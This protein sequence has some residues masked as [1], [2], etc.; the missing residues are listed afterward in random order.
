MG[1]HDPYSDSEWLEIAATTLMALVGQQFQVG[2]HTDVTLLPSSGS[3]NVA[4]CQRQPCNGFRAGSGT[5]RFHVRAHT[6]ANRLPACSR[7]GKR[8][9]VTVPVSIRRIHSELELTP[10]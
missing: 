3:F 1:N 5:G 6:P 7:P 4:A 2:E 8:R 10:F 9:A